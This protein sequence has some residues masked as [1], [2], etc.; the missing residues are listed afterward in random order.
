MP[1]KVKG[2][3]KL[4]FL[5]IYIFFLLPNSRLQMK[6]QLNGLLNYVKNRVDKINL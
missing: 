3:L 4:N 2:K 5:I 1:L 6:I